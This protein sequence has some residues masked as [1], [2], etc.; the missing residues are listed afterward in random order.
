LEEFLLGH[1]VKQWLEGQAD[2]RYIGP[3]LMFGEDDHWPLI[4][5]RCLCLYLDPIKKGE[6]HSDNPFG[7]EID[8]GI[9]FYHPFI[10]SRQFVEFVWIVHFVR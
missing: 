2:D 4:R 6:H 7:H 8:D 3:V 9:P 5:K 10:L 1:K